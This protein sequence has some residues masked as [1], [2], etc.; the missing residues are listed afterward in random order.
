MDFPIQE[1]NYAR[2]LIIRWVSCRNTTYLTSLMTFSRVLY[3][4][5]AKSSAS[6]A[7]FLREAKL[8]DFSFSLKDEML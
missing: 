1:G 7:S 4:S 5:D 6:S 3:N 8:I 2:Q